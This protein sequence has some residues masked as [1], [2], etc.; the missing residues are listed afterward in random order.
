LIQE[1]FSNVLSVCVTSEIKQKKKFA[2]FILDDMVEYLGENIGMKFNDVAQAL[3]SF[4][5][6]Q[7]PAL[8]Q[9]SSYGIGMMAKNCGQL[10][11]GVS[12]N[13]L[14]S[15]KEAIEIPKPAADATGKSKEKQWKHARDNAI[16]ALGKIIRYQ[17]HAI[18]SNE[19]IPSWLSLL[20]ISTDVEEAKIQN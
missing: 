15:L 5:T 14:V 12:Q 11:A 6:N 17:S 7:S 16:S 4:A 10:F 2:L 18:N 13:S 20:P 3:L 19:I 9:A 8:R 1:L